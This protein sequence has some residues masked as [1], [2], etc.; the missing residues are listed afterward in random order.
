MSRDFFE[1]RTQWPPDV[2]VNKIGKL[3]FTKDE[4]SITF[5][6]HSTFII[7]VDGLSIL[8]DPVFSRYASPIQGRGPP[9]HREPAIEIDNL[10]HIDLILVSHN[11]YDHLDEFSIRTIVDNQQNDPPLILAPLGNTLLFKQWG[12]PN[13]VDMDWGDDYQLQNMMIQLHES[14][15]RSGRGLGDQMKTLWGAFVLKTSQGNIYFAGDSGYGPH[16]KR[17]FEQSGPMQLSLLPIGAY[18]PRWFMEA[19]HLDPE[20]AVVAH[21]DLHSELSIGMHYGTFQ[22]T[23]EGID[24]PLIK[25]DRAK[26]KYNIVESEFI[27]IEFGQTLKIN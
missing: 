16:F 5:I 20:Q 23:T 22:L 8:T 7:R 15:H 26:K 4:F 9:R 11:H 18:E 1:T 19:I 21:Q 27:T 10:P 12:I 6:G 25:L 13:S 3:D 14:R 2:A 17:T 24:E